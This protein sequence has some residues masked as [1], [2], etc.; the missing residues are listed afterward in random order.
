[1][2]SSTRLLTRSL[3][4][5]ALTWLAWLAWANRAAIAE[6]TNAANW[7]LLAWAVGALAIANIGMAVVF[8][9]LVQ[10][11]STN[12]P[13]GHVVGVFLLSQVAK[14][15][16]G[17]IWGVAMQA[18]LLPT[19]RIGANVLA[20]NL[21]LAFLNML[22]VTGAGV[23]CIGWIRFGPAAAVVA[24]L[25][26]WGLADAAARSNAAHLIGRCL[27]RV[28]PVRSLRMESVVEMVNVS[29]GS[30]R[31][32]RAGMLLF[33]I[34]YCVGWLLLVRGVTE[35]DWQTCFLVVAALALS[36]IVG[37][38]S[39][40]PAGIGAREG[41]LVLLAPLVGFTQADMAAIAVASR[42]AM[43]VMDAVTALL[44]AFL[45]IGGQRE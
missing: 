33:L 43:L 1:M 15:I 30:F 42:T 20:A 14:Y 6:M 29:D 28:L 45:L 8:A 18:T 35:L 38:V 23:A 9:T 13:Q 40:M 31:D 25:A 2:V 3:M 36:Y 32:R 44:G 41:A 7:G 37:V 19:S 24:L 5:L 34:M 17:R 11:G 16:P 21:E 10:R 26:T 22:L 27:M 12:V 39:L 4:V